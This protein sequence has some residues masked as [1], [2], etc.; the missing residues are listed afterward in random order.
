VAIQ[1]FEHSPEISNRQ[2]HG[3]A[4]GAQA[5]VRIARIFAKSAKAVMMTNRGTSVA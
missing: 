3:W 4:T 1:N 5:L 2:I